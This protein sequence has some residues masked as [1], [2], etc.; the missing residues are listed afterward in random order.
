MAP[1]SGREPVPAPPRPRPGPRLRL[2]SSG[3]ERRRRH[4]G[5][6]REHRPGNRQGWGTGSPPLLSTHR[7]PRCAISRAKQRGRSTGSWGPGLGVQAGWVTRCAEG[8]GVDPAPAVRV[9]AE[10]AQAQGSSP[11]LQDPRFLPSCPSHRGPAVF[12]EINYYNFPRGLCPWTNTL[13]PYFE[14]RS[15]E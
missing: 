9:A 14:T 5:S 6:A 3:G 1:R 7:L 15:A 12:W 10:A 13:D 8:C 11:H 4:K 2:P